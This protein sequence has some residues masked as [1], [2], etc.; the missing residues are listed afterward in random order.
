MSSAERWKPKTSTARRSARR[1]PRARPPRLFDASDSWTDEV[2]AELAA[3]GAVDVVDL[4]GL[5]EGDWLDATPSAELYRRVAEGFPQAW[6]EDARLNDETRPVLEPH[7]DRITWDA[8][9][10]SWADVEA[11]PFA[12]KCLNCK[13]SRFG[14]LERLLEFYERCEQEGIALYGGGQFELGVGRGQIQVLASLFH[15]DAPNDV[16]PGGYNAPEPQPNLEQ[17]PLEPNLE[18]FGFRRNLG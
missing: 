18:P 13:P 12:P 4:K 8:P 14:A 10:H 9:I 3:T 16:A 17:S 11:L 6:L 7:R 15:A 2:V 5:Y 1:R